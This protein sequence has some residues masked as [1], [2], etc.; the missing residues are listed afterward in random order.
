M[1]V[2]GQLC[3]RC[4]PDLDAFLGWAQT[5]LLA[6]F[7]FQWTTLL[8]MWFGEAVVT[9]CL[10]TS[11]GKVCVVP[12]WLCYFKLVAAMLQRWNKQKYVDRLHYLFPSFP[13]P[14]LFSLKEF[15]RKFMK[16]TLWI[17]RVFMVWRALLQFP[18]PLTPLDK[19]Q[20]LLR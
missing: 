6:V 8:Y 5:W 4:V 17:H 1:G 7:F 2:S 12:L 18:D 11:R 15:R 9:Q 20:Q 10:A 13:I 3:K 19:S 14:L 16:A